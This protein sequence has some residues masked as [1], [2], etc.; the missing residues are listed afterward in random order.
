[1]PNKTKNLNLTKPLP[2]EDYNVQ[3]FNDNADKID[4][5]ARATSESIDKL[6]TNMTDHSHALDGT[7][8]KG[9][10]PILKGGTGATTAPEVVKNLGLD[11]LNKHCYVVAAY[12]SSSEHKKYADFVL[13]E[14]GE[15]G[16]N[17]AFYNFIHKLPE[18][19]TV[20]CV[21]G[22]YKISCPIELSGYITVTGSRGGTIFVTQSN[23]MYPSIFFANGASHI[24][25][26]N[27]VLKKDSNNYK[28]PLVSLYDCLDVN[29]SDVEFTYLV[30]D[31]ISLNG[32]NN[33][34][35]YIGG[36]GINYRILNCTIKTNCCDLGSDN[37]YT[38]ECAKTADDDVYSIVFGGNICNSYTAI[39][40]SGSFATEETNTYYKEY[41][42][43]TFKKFIND[44]EEK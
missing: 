44:T 2:G 34:A 25:I 22:T 27:I 18:G 1:M 17:R 16:V 42:N 7:S 43:L 21:P 28:G 15:T 11:G 32:V 23:Y 39:N 19:S 5:F 26:E 38:V 35:I 41:G 12:N 3:D 31:A 30:D 37:F 9:V 13:P 10:L 14:A 33:C 24:A 20:Y 4:G 8:V 36:T 6:A 29:I 40:F